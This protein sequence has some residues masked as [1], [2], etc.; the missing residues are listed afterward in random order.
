[1][2]LVKG[3]LVICILVGA[4]LLGGAFYH[5][6]A[7][8]PPGAAQPRGNQVEPLAGSWKTWVLAS[9]SQLRL[10]PPPDRS[11]TE[12]EIRGLR[13]LAAQRDAAALDRISFWDAGAPGYRWNEILGEEFRKHGIGGATSS[14]EASLM[15]VAIYD[16]TIAA[17]DS[18]YAY[19][20]PRPSE[21]DATLAT[22]LPT[23]SSPSYPAEHAVVAAAAAGVLAYLFP[24]DAQSLMDQAEEAA[25]SRVLAGVQYP[26]DIAAGLELG[27]RV[28]A[29]VVERGQHDGSEAPWQGSVPPGPGTW[30]GTNPVAPTFGTFKPWVLTSGSQLR[31]GPPPAFDS[32]QEA[33]ELAELATFP[34]TFATNAAANFWQTPVGT[35]TYWISLADQKLLEYRL[36]TDPPRA[37]RVLALMSLSAFDATVACWDA[38]YT[39]WAIRPFQLD[40]TFTPVIPTPNHPSYPSA[41]G[42]HSGSQGAMLAHL[43]PRDAA[44]ATE[45]AEEAA[46]SRLWGGIHFRSDID[47]GLALGR[48]VAA[49][50]IERADADGS[51]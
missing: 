33:A 37:A 1:M 5:A 25:Q 38:K 6:A 44:M 29:L 21:V 17:W 43:F 24:D 41:H 42:C 7:Q 10:P 27:R 19:E 20:R 35:S 51:Q 26:S 3:K 4:A 39:Y 47:A 16:A 30:S 8:A 15:H 46:M 23:P 34:R 50:V 2:G 14:R 18:K 13:E 28:A 22:A 11:A 48:T 9:G 49:M 45:R 32:D 36:D 31:P 12:A 40:P